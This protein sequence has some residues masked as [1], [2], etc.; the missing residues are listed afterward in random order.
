MSKQDD[1]QNH[2]NTIVNAEVSTRQLCD[3]VSCTLPTVLTYIKNNPS[4]FTK[5]GRGK[6]RIEPMTMN[7]N[8][9]TT[10]TTETTPVTPVTVVP[11]VESFD[12]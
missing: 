3:A 2:I 10:N 12:W 5:T 8:T 11:N 1:I 4:R 9:S 7:A 6:Y